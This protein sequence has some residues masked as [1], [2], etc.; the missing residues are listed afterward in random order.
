MLVTF[1][2]IG[3]PILSHFSLSGTENDHVILLGYADQ[4]DDGLGI[5]RPGYRLLP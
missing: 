5:T 4:F 2:I 3:S 1:T